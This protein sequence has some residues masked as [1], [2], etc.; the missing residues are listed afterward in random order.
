Q[1]WVRTAPDP[2][3]RRRTLVW[4]VEAM[5]EAIAMREVRS[6]EAILAGALLEAANAD[7]QID[8]LDEAKLAEFVAVLEDLHQRLTAR[9]LHQIPRDGLTGMRP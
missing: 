5:S 4:A 7:D 3:D 9:A 8:E 2:A 6:A 1:G